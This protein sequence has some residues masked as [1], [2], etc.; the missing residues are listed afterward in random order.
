MGKKKQTHVWMYRLSLFSFPE[1][2]WISRMF[3]SIFQ[4][5]S[6]SENSGSARWS[7]AVRAAL[8][9]QN[10]RAQLCLHPAPVKPR[11]GA[12][13][14]GS[15]LFSC[16]QSRLHAAQQES[17]ICRWNWQ[18]KK[19]MIFF[20]IRADK[21]ITTSFIDLSWLIT[22]QPWRTTISPQSEVTGFNFFLEQRNPRLASWKDQV[23]G[24]RFHLLTTLLESFQREYELVF[25]IINVPLRPGDETW[26]HLEPVRHKP[27]GIREKK[28][29]RVRS[30]PRGVSR[31]RGVKSRRSLTPSA[32]Q[33]GSKPAFILFN[34]EKKATEWDHPALEKKLRKLSNN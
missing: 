34:V 17:V 24:Q 26:W 23:T 18:P 16:F 14:C 7:S 20:F 27:D 9:G 5:T 29:K 4:P 25:V 28:S 33:Q 8:E 19:I 22:P 30:C 31:G 1:K 13:V 3:G 10:I 32:R 6:F 12:L 11:L 2:C 15:S 21:T